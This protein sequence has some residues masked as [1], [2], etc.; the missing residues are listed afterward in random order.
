MFIPAGRLTFDRAGL[1]LLNCTS[2]AWRT[3]CFAFFGCWL[4]GI[5]FVLDFLPVFGFAAVAVIL[6]VAIFTINGR[7]LRSWHIPGSAPIWAVRSMRYA[8]LHPGIAQDRRKGSKQQEA[9][10]MPS[11]LG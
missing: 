11:A 7:S 3:V 8:E 6:A 10:V 5:G 1:D 4:G 2:L 9:I